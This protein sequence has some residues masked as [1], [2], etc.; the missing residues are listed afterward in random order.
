M[1]VA[2]RLT[3]VISATR[4]IDMEIRDQQTLVLPHTPGPTG[5]GSLRTFPTFGRGW[6][7]R[8]K[9]TLEQAISMTAVWPIWGD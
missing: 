6:T 1:K 4:I 8:N 3:S 9:V 2:L 7:R 5:Q